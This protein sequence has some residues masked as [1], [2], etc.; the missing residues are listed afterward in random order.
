MLAVHKT[1]SI[2]AHWINRLIFLCF[3]LSL[4]FSFSAQSLPFE[5]TEE[6]APCDNYSADKV[7]LFG[8]L[9]VHS[10]YSF[11]SYGS[12]QRNDPWDA[13]RYAKGETI[14]LPNIDGEQAIAAQIH[15][16]LDFTSV[17]DHGG[18]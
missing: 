3:F 4:S 11:D 14:M 8:D 18:H 17:T 16:P 1:P 10:R 6:R 13:Y 2:L 7:P 5:R 12:N 9:H 15:R